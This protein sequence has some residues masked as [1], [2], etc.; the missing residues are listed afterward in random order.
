MP[1]ADDTFQSYGI[2]WANASNTP[3]RLYK[4]WVHE[5]GISTPL[6]ARWPKGIARRNTVTHEPGHLIVPMATCVDVSGAAY[7][8]HHAGS[9]VLPM[10]G[11]S[12]R[13]AFGGKPIRR[14]DAIYW[15]HEGNRAVLDGMTALYDQ[16]AARANVVPWEKVQN[17]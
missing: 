10:E 1:G 7:P 6:I 16:W 2:G 13:P 3:F 15:E 17:S 14:D 9:A 8:A 12:L 5:G 11:S 4:H